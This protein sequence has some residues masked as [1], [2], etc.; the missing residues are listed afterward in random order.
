[1]IDE[2]E[3][4]S[5]FWISYAFWVT[6]LLVVA[7]VGLLLTSSTYGQDTPKAVWV[8]SPVPHWSCPVVKSPYPKTTQGR[9]IPS[10]QLTAVG[11][12]IDI[13]GD[14]ILTGYVAEKVAAPLIPKCVQAQP[15]GM[16]AAPDALIKFEEIHFVLART[17]PRD[18]RLI[19][20]TQ[21][22]VL[23]RF[24]CNISGDEKDHI[25]PFRPEKDRWTIEGKPGLQLLF[26]CQA[27]VAR[28]KGNVVTISSD[29]PR[30]TAET[31]TGHI[32][33]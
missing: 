16:N 22:E 2:K 31:P 20:A 27:Y 18:G 33:Y 7:I 17:I 29:A 10:H 24:G 3:R 12:V 19:I 26:D 23:Q 11:V 1:M 14:S 13:D 21:P 6:I 9:R 25:K 28:E 8:E 4:D 15:S 30:S 5:A 32:Q